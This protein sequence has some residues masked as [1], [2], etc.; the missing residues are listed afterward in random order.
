MVLNSS[1][2]RLVFLLVVSGASIS[3]LGAPD[4]RGVWEHATCQVQERDGKPSG[5]RSLFAIF[6]RE[7][8]LAFTQYGDA[9]CRTPI[10]TAVFRGTYESTKPS[11]RV[12]GAFEATFRFSYKGVVAHDSALVARLN[13]GLCGDRQWKPGVEQD[14]TSTGCMTIESASACPQEYDLVSMQGEEL[15]LGERPRPGENICVEDR[16]PQRLRTVSLRRR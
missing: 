12:P 9:D 3:A 1:S 10:M 7:W 2:Q 6:D 5:S 14:V 4:I 16:R 11:P 8:G 15:F 13:T